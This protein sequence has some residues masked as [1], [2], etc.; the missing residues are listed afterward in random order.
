MI[1]LFAQMLKMVEA[2]RVPAKGKIMKLEKT[3][4]VFQSPING[5]VSTMLV[6]ILKVISLGGVIHLEH[7]STLYVTV[8]H[9]LVVPI[10]STMEF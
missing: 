6:V 4:S 10:L 2:T 1:Q 5:Q 8:H 3:A 9:G 7:L